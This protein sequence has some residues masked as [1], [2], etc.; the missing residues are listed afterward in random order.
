MDDLMY[1]LAVHRECGGTR[2]RC[3]DRVHRGRYPYGGQGWYAGPGAWRGFNSYGPPIPA[4]HHSCGPHFEGCRPSRYGPGMHGFGPSSHT[5]GSESHG[6][7]PGAHG[8][9]QGH[10]GPGPHCFG[11]GFYRYGP[12]SISD[13]AAEFCP[14]SQGPSS[15]IPGGPP[16]FMWYGMKHHHKFGKRKFAQ[17]DQQ[18]SDS[19]SPAVSPPQETKKE[20]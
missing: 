2:Q 5:C 17:Q 6:S 10:R 19:E 7:G 12:G 11:P 18:D 20:Q 16:P 4:D 8:Y 9:R 14:S 1:D 3:G 13:K 15:S